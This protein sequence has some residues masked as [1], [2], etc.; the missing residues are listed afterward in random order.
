V[1][2]FIGWENSAALAEETDNPRRNVPRAV[3]TSVLIMGVGYLL[4]AYATVSGF[5]YNVTKLGA[6]PIPFITVAH[7]TLGAF[8]VFAYLAGMTSTLGALIAGTNSQAR[9]V[10]NAGREGLI[11]R[12]IG[13]VHSGR[14]TPMNAIFTF[15][16]IST[17]IIGGWALLHLI[18]GSTGALDPINFFFESS[19]MGTILVLVVYLLSNLALPVYYRKYRPQE[20]DV[21]KHAVLPGLGALAIIVPLYYLAKPGQPTPYDWFPYAALIVVVVAAVIAFALN[22]RDPELAGRVGSIVADE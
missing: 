1:Y 17:L 18:G 13:K 3:F 16:G 5:G 22:R 15:V 20:F 6:A 21:I 14:L 9:L 19:T 11:P 8:A 7:D 12:W 2:I 4:F 10:F